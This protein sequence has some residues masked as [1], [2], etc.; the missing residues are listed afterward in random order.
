MA[1]CPCSQG[2]ANVNTIRTDYN[3]VTKQITG[4][5]TKD[6]VTIKGDGTVVDAVRTGNN[7]DTLIIEGGA[8]VGSSILGT[9]NDATINTTNNS[10]NIVIDAISGDKTIDLSNLSAADK[11]IKSIDLTNVNDVKLNITAEDV[12]DVNK[13]TGGTL[14]IKGGSDDSVAKTDESKWTSEP[15]SSTTDYSTSVGSET[16]IIKID[17]DINTNNL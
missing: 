12:L 13:A 9:G 6:T 5:H 15:G 11:N 2:G 14:E 1:E 17:N 7:D 4:G 10:G 16:V 3:F 8:T